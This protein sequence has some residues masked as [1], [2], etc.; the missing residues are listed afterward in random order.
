MPRVTVTQNGDQYVIHADDHPADLESK[1]REVYRTV[2]PAESLPKSERKGTRFQ[3]LFNEGP[4][5]F[6][7]QAIVQESGERIVQLGG[8]Q[9]SQRRLS[10]T[11]A[12][13]RE[14]GF[15]IVQ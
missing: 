11:L 12:K 4:V 8:L 5:L 6:Q 10:A 2:N 13:L 15:E 14:L 3:A 1:L 7:E 9:V